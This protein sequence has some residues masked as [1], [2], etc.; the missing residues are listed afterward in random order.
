MW[1]MLRLSFHTQEGATALHI[2]AH[3]DKPQRAEMLIKAGA[4]VNALDG[5]QRTPLMR[6]RE[7]GNP[8]CEALLVAAEAAAVV[9]AKESIEAQNALAIAV[10]RA[11][12]ESNRL[13]LVEGAGVAVTEEV[14]EMTHERLQTLVTEFAQH[15]WEQMYEVSEELRR[16]LK[17][18]LPAAQGT[19]QAREALEM[20]AVMK[21]LVGGARREVAEAMLRCAITA[22]A[23][24]KR[25][26]GVAE[27]LLSPRDVATASAARGKLDEEL[28]E[29]KAALAEHSE[30]AESSDVLREARAL[31]D[32]MVEESRRAR[33][34]VRTHCE[35]CWLGSATA[36]YR[37]LLG[38]TRTPHAR[39]GR[40]TAVRL[41]C[42][43][44]SGALHT[45][46]EDRCSLR[47]VSPNSRL[48]ITPGEEGREE[49]Q[50]GREATA[51]VG[52]ESGG[53]GG[54]HGAG[55]T[56]GGCGQGAGGD[57]AGRDGAGRVGAAEG[58]FQG[59]GGDGG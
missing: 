33:E 29:L 25:L 1:L 34:E 8:E 51:T 47:H 31:R 57:G 16:Q 27:A 30:A 9:K 15:I 28:A 2:V 32:T 22:A 19:P 37:G 53:G 56:P 48:S 41:S 26:Y 46:R 20:A 7:A 6:A 59:E 45:R 50:G 49:S 54:G 17:C 40:A 35:K 24:A 21:K 4:N 14:A 10:T 52:G 55:V 43:R 36:S 38:L 39:E 3:F 18:H 11:Q 5:Q 42:S 58:E 12:V 13:K 23:A 44:R